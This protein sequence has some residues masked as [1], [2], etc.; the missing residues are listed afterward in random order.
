MILIIVVLILLC[1]HP[2]INLLQS[3]FA[4]ALQISQD[5]RVLCLKD[6]NAGIDGIIN[7][8][9][10]SAFS[11]LL[12]GVHLIPSSRK[13]SGQIRMLYI[14]SVVMVADRLAEELVQLFG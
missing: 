3:R 7:D 2:I 13:Y 1:V 11:M 8:Y 10:A 12:I 6:C 4:L 5:S 14:F 9:I